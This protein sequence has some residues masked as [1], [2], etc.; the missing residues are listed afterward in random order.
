MLE[1]IKMYVLSLDGGINKP[2]IVYM[3]FNL[4]EMLEVMKANNHNPMNYMIDEIDIIDDAPEHIYIEFKFDDVSNY[5][6]IN[7]SYDTKYEF[8]C[9]INQE[10]SLESQYI[11]KTIFLNISDD[12]PNL[13]KL[14]IIESIEN[15]F[16][17]V[18][19]H[20][21]LGEYAYQKIILPKNL[22]RNSIIVRDFVNSSWKKY[23]E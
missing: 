5:W 4:N 10:Y 8:Y 17:S 14:D 19:Y 22:N 12:I 3:G 1:K 7:A 2:E 15:N 23:D 11:G 6:K 9:Y 16:E 13:E 20:D 18:K 21:G